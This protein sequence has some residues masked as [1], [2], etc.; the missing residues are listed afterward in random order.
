MYR[1]FDGGY[2]YSHPAHHTD[3]GYSCSH[4]AHHTDG[5]YPYSHSAPIHENLDVFSVG[6]EPGTVWTKSPVECRALL[7]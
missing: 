1:N 7:H 5:G 4:P 3:G 6:V 2:P